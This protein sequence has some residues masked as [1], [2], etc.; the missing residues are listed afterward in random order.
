MYMDVQK[1]AVAS[2]KGM[3]S[4]LQ[5]PPTACLGAPALLYGAQALSS[6]CFNAE[7]T[8]THLVQMN[9][10]VQTDHDRLFLIG[11]SRVST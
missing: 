2:V 8:A 1:T 9:V 11:K 6:G 4:T 7:L 10:S 5:L 3:L